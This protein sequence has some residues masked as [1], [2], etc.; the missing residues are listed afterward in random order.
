MNRT[1]GSIQRG[2][3]LGFHSLFVLVFFKVFGVFVWV[4]DGF[5]PCSFGFV[6]FDCGCCF[7]C[8]AKLGDSTWRQLSALRM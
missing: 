3:Q 6:F 8:A 7:G 4:F 2:S 5:V 1:T